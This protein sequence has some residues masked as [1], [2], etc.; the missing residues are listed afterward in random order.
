MKK[1]AVVT[2]SGDGCKA[3]IPGRALTKKETDSFADAVTQGRE[4]GKLRF[5]TVTK[6]DDATMY[7][8]VAKQG[9]EVEKLVRKK[10]VSSGAIE[11]KRLKGMNFTV[12]IAT[13]DAKTGAATLHTSRVNSLAA[14]AA[15]NKKIQDAFKQVV[16]ELDYNY[17]TGL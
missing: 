15:E 9:E 3:Y 17:T 7:D 13:T 4:E 5:S 10:L 12:N 1:N 16:K 8:Y 6:M 2:C 11:P 14:S